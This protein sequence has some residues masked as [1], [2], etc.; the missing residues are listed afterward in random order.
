M[1]MTMD[2][3]DRMIEEAAESRT[4]DLSEVEGSETLT[5]QSV[6]LNK[7]SRMVTIYHVT[8]GEPR[9]MPALAAEI[10]LRKKGKDPNDPLYRK[11][12]FSP[13]PTREY[14]YGT[15]KCLLHPDN[16][17]RG[18]YDKWGLP[19]CDTAHIA[20]PGEVQR[21]MVKRHPS[22]NAI[23]REAEAEARRQEEREDNR[24][25]AESVRDAMQQMAGG[26]PAAAATGAIATVDKQAIVDSATPQAPVLAGP[27]PHPHQYTG[28]AV[29]SPCK[30]E[31]CAA[32][33]TTAYQKR[34]PRK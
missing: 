20:S 10:A 32:V 2:A 6:E 8:T 14:H 33:R 19:V 22:A 21:H 28:K 7:A 27:F 4:Q 24:A 30:I 23:I 16:P 5:I 26:T 11:F 3:I 29:G 25:L 34:K 13:K 18:E 15:A 12:I 17:S 31:G 1:T 9:R